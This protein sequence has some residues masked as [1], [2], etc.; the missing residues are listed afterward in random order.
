MSGA[1]PGTAAIVTTLRNAGAVLDTFVAYHRAIGFAHFFLFF[2]DPFDPD[3][4]RARDMTGVT[5]IAGDGE[6]KEIWRGL[7]GYQQFGDSTRTEVMSRQL[8]NAEY[9]MRLARERG[10]DWLLHIDSDELFYSP[11]ETAAEHFARLTATPAETSVYLN[12]EAIPE[13]EEIADYF[14]EVDLFKL[15]YEPVCTQLAAALARAQRT[16]PQLDPFFHF[17]ANGKSA[18]RLKAD[19]LNPASVHRFARADAVAVA[20]QSTRQFI[21]HYAC[22]G[23]ETFWTKYVTLGPFADKWWGIHDIAAAIG[24]FHLQARDVVARGR[25][26]ARA[27]YRERIAISGAGIAEELIRLG[28]ATRL[29]GPRRIAGRWASARPPR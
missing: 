19:G 13:R 14:R 23:F 27:F 17:Y 22:C 2:D 29:A 24:P 6:L 15:P 20:V 26:A 12:Y 10:H 9:A 7:S 16:V 28:L 3:L 4:M 21:L 5:A 18:V 11:G 25:E 1:G 8:L